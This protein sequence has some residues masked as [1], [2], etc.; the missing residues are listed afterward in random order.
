MAYYYRRRYRRYFRKY[1]R[2]GY[3]RR[4]FYS[5]KI[6]NAKSLNYYV[7]KINGQTAC[8]AEIDQ[9]DPN[10]KING[11]KFG[12]VGNWT[13][14]A[15]GLNV[16][17]LLNSST[18]YAKYKGMFN[19]VMLLGIRIKA[20]PTFRSLAYQATGAWTGDVNIFFNSDPDHSDI[21]EMDPF[22]LPSTNSVSRYWKN[23]NKHWY[24]SSLTTGEQATGLLNMGYVYLGYTDLKTIVQTKCP[25]WN[26]YF[27]VYVKFRKNRLNQ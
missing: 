14:A 10:N 2:K 20:V 11:F 25:S 16:I 3:F 21:T 8:F 15:D 26:L 13:Q 9:N 7:A 5:R 1:S 18:E 4:T 17:T 19:E 6:A 27:T 22:T 24:P 23:L 12:T